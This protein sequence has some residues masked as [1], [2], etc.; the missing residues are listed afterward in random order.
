MA[1]I[2]CPECGKQVSD[3]AKACPNCGY[4]FE[5][6]REFEKDLPDTTAELFGW[7]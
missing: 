5:A 3:T 6:V 4:D 7:R 1:L 2:R